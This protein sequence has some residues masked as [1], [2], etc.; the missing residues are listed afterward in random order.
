MLCF[1]VTTVSRFAL[2]SHYLRNNWHGRV[3]VANR[4]FFT[5][6]F[7]IIECVLGDYHFAHVLLGVDTQRPFTVRYLISLSSAFLAG[8]SQRMFAMFNPIIHCQ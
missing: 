1:L 5:I 8:I 7:M 2:L 4:A 3:D 6:N